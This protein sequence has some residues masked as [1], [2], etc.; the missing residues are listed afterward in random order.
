[1]N[2]I[3]NVHRDTKYSQPEGYTIL[4]ALLKDC[5]RPMHVYE[6]WISTLHHLGWHR[7]TIQYY[8]CCGIE[9]DEWFGCLVGT[10]NLKL[11]LISARTRTSIRMTIWCHKSRPG[12]GAY[13][14]VH[15]THRSRWRTNKSFIPFHQTSRNQKIMNFSIP[16]S[17]NSESICRSNFNDWSFHWLLCLGVGNCGLGRVFYWVIGD[18]MFVFVYSISPK[19]H[20]ETTLQSEALTPKTSD[21]PSIHLFWE[22]FWI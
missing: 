8:I 12:T 14:E 19:N 15:C 4:R 10:T 13:S 20:M 7:N 16:S 21:N 1:M 2:I 5:G 17:K 6:L 3:H 18:V 11:T 22:K 9:M